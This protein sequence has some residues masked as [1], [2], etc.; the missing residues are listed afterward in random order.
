MLFVGYGVFKGD[1]MNLFM[2][3]PTFPDSFSLH[4]ALLQACEGAHYGG[5]AY[6]FVSTG[7]AKLFLED[8]TFARFVSSGNFK[9]I[10]GIDEIT[11]ENALKKLSEL[12]EIYNN[13][14]EVFAFLHDT[15]VSMFH[16]KFSW[17]KNDEG[18]ILILGSG[19]LTERGLRRNW[20]AFNVIEVEDIKFEEVEGIWK[21]W[22]EH[23]AN[24]L[25]HIDDN[26]VIERVKENARVYS[27]VKRR[28]KHEGDAETPKDAEQ[29][30]EVIEDVDL[31]AWSFV[32]DNAVLIAEIPDNNKRWKQA[33][34][35]K[36]SFTTFFGAKIGNN[37]LRIL[38][39]N[40]F[41]DGSLGDIEVRPYIAVKSQ[42][43]RI[44]LKAVSSKEYP[45][46][47]R[48]IGI[49]LRVST[50]MFLY[51]LAMPNDHFYIEIRE[52]LNKKY[53]GRIDRMKRVISAVRELKDDC[54]HLPFWHAFK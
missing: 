52:F 11:S 4:E 46:D 53:T 18:G 51:V 37:S 24:N 36:N 8:D 17:F 21:N 35:D 22:L 25:R 2:Q 39:R 9:L 14:L 34:F 20:E 19:N 44:E 16:P 42:N 13:R 15:T 54:E 48:P 43:Y 10:V 47:G 7:G 45:K 5:G 27:K 6:A 40:V 30:E 26:D 41:P 38:L 29:T 28:A 12:K 49:F 3:D 23:N 33:N 31:D 32:E 50:R 1:N